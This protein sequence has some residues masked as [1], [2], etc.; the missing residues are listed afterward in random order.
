[1]FQLWGCFQV[2]EP[3][4]GKVALVPALTV[5]ALASQPG[6][7]VQEPHHVKAVE[8][9]HGGAAGDLSNGNY[10]FSWGY[11]SALADPEKRRNIKQWLLDPKLAGGGAM[12]D[13]GV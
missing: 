6:A 9:L 4:V 10:E 13:T 2:E 12:F 11:A 7:S 3:N 5:S 8:A 1:M